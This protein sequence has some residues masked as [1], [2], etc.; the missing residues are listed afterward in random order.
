MAKKRVDAATP[1]GMLHYDVDE[2][3]RVIEGRSARRPTCISDR[4]AGR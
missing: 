1:A 3:G 2:F 4:I